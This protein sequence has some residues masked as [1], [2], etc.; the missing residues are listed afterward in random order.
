M[1]SGALE[2]TARTLVPENK[3]NTQLTVFVVANEPAATS[4]RRLF[5]E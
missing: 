1:Q 3:S 4:F 5:V 2:Y